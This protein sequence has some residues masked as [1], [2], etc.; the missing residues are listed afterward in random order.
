[1]TH[2]HPWAWW[3]WAL[4]LAA[5]LSLTTNPLLI[6]LLV[7]AACVVV[8]LRRTDAPWA[9]SLW[10]YAALAGFIVAFRLFFHILMG[11]QGGGTVL[12]ALPQIELP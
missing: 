4:G 9:R 12:F 7:L 10:V 11:A 1:M 6:A 8:L 5:A 2:A 3:A